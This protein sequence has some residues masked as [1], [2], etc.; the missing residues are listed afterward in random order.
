MYFI[1]LTARTAALSFFQNPAHD[2]DSDPHLIFL[3]LWN[4]KKVRIR[5]ENIRY[6]YQKTRSGVHKIQPVYQNLRKVNL[7]PFP[8][9]PIKIH[10]RTTCLFYGV[11]ENESCHGLYWQMQTFCAVKRPCSG[12]LIKWTL[13]FRPIA[14]YATNSERFLPFRFFLL[15]F[16]RSYIFRASVCATC[17]YLVWLSQE[18]KSNIWAEIIILNESF[19]TGTI[20]RLPFWLVQT[21]MMGTADSPKRR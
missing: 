5:F 9:G 2:R 10:F 15:L 16:V 6:Q 7:S 18:A 8:C 13:R 14:T 12:V 11:C 21:L 4:C 1:V 3:A 19:G 20:N 17:T